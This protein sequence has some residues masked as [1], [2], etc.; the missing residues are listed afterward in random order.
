ML[1]SCLAG[2]RGTT[3]DLAKF[4][5]HEGMRLSAIEIEAQ[6]PISRYPRGWGASGIPKRFRGEWY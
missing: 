2:I 1:R 4:E 3:H 6:I 5:K